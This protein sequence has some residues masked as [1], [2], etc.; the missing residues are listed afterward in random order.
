MYA[1][2]SYYGSDIAIA[3][4]I[5]TI[6]PNIIMAITPQKPS[7]PT[8]KPKRKNSIAPKIVL[9]AVMNTGAVPNRFEVVSGIVLI[10]IMRVI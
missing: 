10:V 8:A 4:G 3:V 6:W 7:V 5:V 1:I 9:M 2:R